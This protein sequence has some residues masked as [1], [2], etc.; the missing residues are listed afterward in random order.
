[1]ISKCGDVTITGDAR[2]IARSYE[3]LAYD[4]KRAGNQ[5]EAQLYFN[6]AEHYKKILDEKDA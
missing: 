4:A 3:K 2:H 1:M 6:H 5:T